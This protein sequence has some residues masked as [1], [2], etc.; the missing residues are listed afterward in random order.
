[1]YEVC[2][3]WSQGIDNQ[4][5]YFFLM[6]TDSSLTA[7]RQAYFG[8]INQYL[9]WHDGYEADLACLDALTPTEREQAAQELLEALRA[10]KADARAVLGLGYLHY[11]AALPLLHELLRRHMASFYAL[12]AIAQI[13]PAGLYQP[14]LTALLTPKIGDYQ[15]IDL[16]MGLR[17]AFTRP[18]LE[19]P[20]LRQVFT[21]LTHPDYL[22]RYHALATLRRLYGLQSAAQELMGDANVL[23]QDALFKLMNGDKRPANY[24]QAQQLLLTQ[25]PA[26]E[27][28]LLQGR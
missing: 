21:L 23:R 22:V 5:N 24:R 8:P 12:G 7:F 9:A 17:T 18:Q 20:V 3:I 2:R 14:L 26:A 4:R 6:T 15:L 16:L 28:E 19:P 13:N 25:L 27:R 10:G 1:M 11:E